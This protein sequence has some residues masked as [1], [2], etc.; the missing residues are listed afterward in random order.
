MQREGGLRVLQ[1]GGGYSGYWGS[2]YKGPVSLASGVDLEDS[3]FNIMQQEI[4]M[5]CSSGFQGIFGVAFKEINQVSVYST[6]LNW[7]SCIGELSDA[8]HAGGPFGY[9][10]VGCQGLR[11]G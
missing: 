11:C 2:V 7:S 10:L 4:N 8:R 1:H 6:P 9:L 3:Y 5:P